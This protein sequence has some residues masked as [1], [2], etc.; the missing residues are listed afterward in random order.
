[1]NFGI[2]LDYKKQGSNVDAKKILDALIK[3]LNKWKEA[4]PPRRAGLFRNPQLFVRAIMADYAK[5]DK[6]LKAY[7]SLEK[8]LGSVIAQKLTDNKLAGGINPTLLAQGV[9]RVPMLLKEMQKFRGVSYGDPKKNKPLGE[10]LNHLN[11]KKFYKEEFEKLSNEVDEKYSEHLYE[12]AVEWLKTF[13]NIIGDGIQDIISDLTIATKGGE[14]KITLPKSV[15][16]VRKNNDKVFNKSNYTNNEL[17]KN[18]N[19]ENL[20]KENDSKREEAW[21]MLWIKGF[22]EAYFGLED[23]IRRCSNLFKP[24]TKPFK[25][26]NEPPKDL[27]ILPKNTEAFANLLDRGY[28]NFAKQIKIIT[29]AILRSSIEDATI[30]GSGSHIVNK[31]GMQKVDPK[32]FK[33][34]KED[35]VEEIN[36]S[37][38]AIE[39]IFKGWDNFNKKGNVNKSRSS[40]T[41]VLKK[42]FRIK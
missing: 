31:S 39:I 4:T 18:K 24:R 28:A 32:L 26:I 38:K 41:G 25:A 34:R 30:S 15:Q 7:K 5:A 22:K 2:E 20:K 11:Q 33:E 1:M 36:R 17:K 40:I 37:L 21:R 16:V 13:N 29:N 27:D 14:I 10:L 8:K 19:E 9:M 3:F 6:F 42:L 12:S 35:A 23:S